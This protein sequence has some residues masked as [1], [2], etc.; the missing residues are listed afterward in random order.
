MDA[1][2]HSAAQSIASSAHFA[3]EGD[4]RL[5]Y[6]LLPRGQWPAH[7]W[8]DADVIPQFEN[9]FQMEDVMVFDGAA[10]RN[11]LCSNGFGLT[12]EKLA[13]SLHGVSEELVQRITDNMPTEKRASFLAEFQRTVSEDQVEA[14]RHEVLDRLFWGLTYWKTPDFYEEVTEGEQ[15]HPQIFQQL[16]LDVRGNIVLDAGAGSGRASLECVRYGAKKVYAVEPSPGL[17]RILQKKL[18]SNRVVL[19]QGHFDVLP[20]YNQSVDLAIS[21]SAFTAEEAQGGESGLA[22]LRRVTKPGGKVVIIWPRLQDYDWLEQHGFTYVRLPGQEEMSVHFRSMQSALRC[23][24]HFY[25]HNPKVAQYLERECTPDV[26][27]SILGINPPC[28][29]CWLLVD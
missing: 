2:D 16:E 21:C 19:C 3:G 24:R 25:A 10:L 7:R 28:D 1:K 12:V 6:A 14:A 27:Y 8:F 4:E 13:E 15:L 9:L 20:L 26:P 23:A 17:L 22:E 18:D 5:Q 11:I 29:Y